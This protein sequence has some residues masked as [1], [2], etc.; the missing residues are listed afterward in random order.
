MALSYIYTKYK[1]VYTV[2]N[3]GLVALNYTVSKK[4]CDITTLVTNGIIPVSS[5]LTLPFNF[6]DGVYVVT[7]SDGFE[8]DTLSDILYYN[9]LLLTIIENVEKSLCGC[10]P[11]H[12]CEDCVDCDLYLNTLT[13]VLAF[14]YVNHPLYS[15]SI[16]LVNTNMQC[17]F[18]ESVLCMLTKSM[19]QGDEDTKNIF[20]Q[21]IGMHYLAFYAYDIEQ[22]E[23]AEE[24]DYIKLKY[25]TSKIFKCLRRIGIDVEA[26]LD[27]LP[28]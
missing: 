7:I 22:A 21:I 3:T 11:C 16:S 5:T 9:N 13:Q 26:M 15:A 24:I 8:I 25:N 12:E 20:L 19:I 1:D 18:T 14:A 4:E 6:I 27:E 23:D 2:Q 17:Q 28:A 10:K